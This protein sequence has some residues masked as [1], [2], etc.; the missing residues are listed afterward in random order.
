MEPGRLSRYMIF[1]GAQS[2]LR[3]FLNRDFF[4][5]CRTPRRRIFSASR[6][7]WGNFRLCEA[8]RTLYTEYITPSRTIRF[9]GDQFGQG[10]GIPPVYGPK[11][12][13]V[14]GKCFSQVAKSQPAQPEDRE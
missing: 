13:P 3:R 10:G 14:H 5:T 11:H 7:L 2:K 6:L 8:P 9:R 12:T 1:H 4:G